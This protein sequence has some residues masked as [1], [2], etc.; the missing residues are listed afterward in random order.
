MDTD[1]ELGPEAAAMTFFISEFA[2]GATLENDASIEAALQVLIAVCIP[3]AGFRQH[4]QDGE[5]VD[6][7]QDLFYKGLEQRIDRVRHWIS[8]NVARFPSS[9]QDVRNLFNKV[10]SSALAMRANVRICSSTCS[11]CQLHCLRPYRHADESHDCGTD[12]QCLFDC[13]IAEDHSTR[14]P[15]GLP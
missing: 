5:Y 7:L 11:D 8:L 1:E 12:H 14:E 15:C 9:N 6:E 10:N 13:A 4:I 2:G 3:S